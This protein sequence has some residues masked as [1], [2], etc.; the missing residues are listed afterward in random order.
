MVHEVAYVVK[1]K[2]LWRDPPGRDLS[3]IQCYSCKEYGHYSSRCK[4]K[5]CN[6]I[7]ATIMLSQNVGKGHKNHKNRAYHATAPSSDTTLVA[8]TSCHAFST[9]FILGKNPPLSSVWYFDSKPSNHKT[10]SIIFKMFNRM[11]VSSKSITPTV[12]NYPSSQSVM[13]TILYLCSIFLFLSIYL[14]M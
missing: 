12:R 2:S 8:S 14:Q 6:Y 7:K 1:G 9:L 4:R 11:M 5:I 10:A 3:K 13:Y